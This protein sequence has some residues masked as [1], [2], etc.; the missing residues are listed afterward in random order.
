MEDNLKL[1]CAWCNLVIRPG[2]TMQFNGEEHASHGIC[3]T[4]FEKVENQLE[5]MGKDN[6][7]QKEKRAKP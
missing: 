6:A 7:T 5:K 1:I 4:C 3:K 2:K